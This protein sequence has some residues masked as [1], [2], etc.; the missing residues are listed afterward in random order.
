MIIGSYGGAQYTQ[1][2]DIMFV[3]VSLILMEIGHQMIL[4]SDHEMILIADHLMILITGHQVILIAD[5]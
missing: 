4:I 2:N 3:T 1:H 5:H